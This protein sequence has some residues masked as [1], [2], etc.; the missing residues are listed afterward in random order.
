MLL[1]LTSPLLPHL[2]VCV[3]CVCARAC[4]RVWFSFKYASPLCTQ[5]EAANSTVAIKRDAYIRKF[6]WT[7]LKIW[8]Q[9]L[10]FLT[11]YPECCRNNVSYHLKRKQRWL[12]KRKWALVIWRRYRQW[13]WH[14]SLFS[15]H[16]HERSH[17]TSSSKPPLALHFQ[18]V[19]GTNKHFR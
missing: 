5:A 19:S 8:S 9:P 2:C 11:E 10:I 12:P 3:L 1:V 4:V 7:T 6:K 14:F 18:P 17:Q 16:A 13:K 15:L